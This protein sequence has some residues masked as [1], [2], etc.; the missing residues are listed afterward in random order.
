MTV[1]TGHPLLL[2]Q[3]SLLPEAPA[4][5]LDVRCQNG[6]SPSREGGPTWVQAGR[7][8]CVVGPPVGSAPRVQSPGRE[9]MS[10]VKEGR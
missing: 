6:W 8:P 2:S 9:G 10:E 5:A 3:G 4:V 1:A 7:G